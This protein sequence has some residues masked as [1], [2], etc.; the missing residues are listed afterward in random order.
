MSLEAML[1]QFAQMPVAYGNLYG[2]QYANLY[3]PQ[4][5]Y[6]QSQA[7]NM[8][9]LGGQSMGLYG[10]LAGQQASMYSNELPMRMEMAKWNAL[11]PALSGLL[12]Q[13]GFSGVNLPSLEMQFNRPDVMAGYGG[14][15]SNAYGNARS[16]DGFM[17]QN[18]QNHQQAMQS[19]MPKN[20]FAAGAPAP[21][22]PAGPGKK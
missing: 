13:I 4:Y 5:S 11:A 1:G 16:Y 3:N 7:G 2:N 21:A 20:P 10:N 12:N 17:Q 22:S 14:A 9:Q 15:V 19:A 18:F 8:A 6:G